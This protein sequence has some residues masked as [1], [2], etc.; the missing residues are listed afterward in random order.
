MTDEPNPVKPW[1]IAAKCPSCELRVGKPCDNGMV[2]NM[3]VCCACGWH[4]EETSLIEI[5]KAWFG[6]GANEAR[7]ELERGR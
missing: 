5:A 7:E 1:C 3:L 2:P 6:H 4:W